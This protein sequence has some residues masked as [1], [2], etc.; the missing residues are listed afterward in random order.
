MS[1][2]AKVFFVASLGVTSV[3]IFGVHWVQIK[4]REVRSLHASFWPLADGGP[5]R[6]RARQ[7]MFAGVLRDEA[8]M[9]AK[10]AARQ[11]EYDEQLRKRE[12][13]ESIQSVGSAGSSSSGQQQTPSS[14]PGSQ[15]PQEFDWGCKTC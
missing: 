4:E 11:Q 5:V 13:L 1:R 15:S 6:L 12:Y 10:R 2:A 8:R 14:H 7:T 3:T 9:Q